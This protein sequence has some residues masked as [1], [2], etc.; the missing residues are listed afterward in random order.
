M[1][2]EHHEKDEL[3]SIEQKLDRIIQLLII[4]NRKQP[5]FI[6]EILNVKWSINGMATNAISLNMDSTAKA[7]GV[8]QELNNDGSVF[9][10]NPANI[11]VQVQDATVISA[12]V[13]P[14]TGNITVVPLKVG[15]TLL[16][17]QDTATNVASPTYTFT[18]AASTVTPSTLSVTWTVT[19]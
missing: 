4:L 3:D 8:V 12:T 19:P 2:G 9:T 18:V 13:D 5:V 6:P 11:A 16:A 10:Y 15:Q 1:P 14:T 17:V 7:V